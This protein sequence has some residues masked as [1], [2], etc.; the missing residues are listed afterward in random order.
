M[1]KYDIHGAIIPLVEKG[2]LT[3]MGG[4]RKKGWKLV[5]KTGNEVKPGTLKTV[6]NYIQK[7]NNVYKNKAYR[8][9][10][11]ADITVIGSN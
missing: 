1:K 7:L 10:N 9:F 3:P 6:K 4:L 11:A 2:W 5:L 8:Q